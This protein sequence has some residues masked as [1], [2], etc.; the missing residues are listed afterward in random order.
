MKEIGML[1]T[2]PR[3]FQTI[4]CQSRGGLSMRNITTI[5]SSQFS[6]FGL[7]GL[8]LAAALL[9]GCSS[10]GLGN[11]DYGCSGMPDGVRCLSA[12]EVYELTS[13]GAAPKS[14]ET[15]ATRIGSSSGSTQSDL[16]TGM[17]SHPAIPR[18]EQSAPIRVPSRVM[19]IWIAPW[20]DERGDL[21]LPGYVFTEI[22]P[23][24]W[25]VGVPAPHTVSPVLRPLQSQ[26]GQSTA[27]ADGQ[28]QGM[29]IYG[30]SNE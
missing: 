1:L 16:E 10:L 25:E 12:R 17:L 3:L 26:G 2:D 20:E 7:I 19:R 21:N 8:A 27:G 30:E 4:R 13:N 9:S 18:A 6:R 24:R 28:R 29:S 15:V 22:E 23:R 14:I 5:Q 11:S